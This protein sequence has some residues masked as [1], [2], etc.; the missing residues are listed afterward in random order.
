[1]PPIPIP[2]LPSDIHTVLVHGG[3]HGAWCW[4]RVETELRHL[5]VA[6]PHSTFRGV[7][8]TERRAL[9]S[10]LMTSSMPLLNTPR[11]VR[12]RRDACAASAQLLHP[13]GIIRGQFGARR[14]RISMGPLL[15]ALKRA[16]CASRLRAT[17]PSGI[18]TNLSPAVAG[19][20]DVDYPR[21]YIAM[22]EDLTYPLEVVRTFA[23]KAGV[24]PIVI[25]GDHCVM[26]SDAPRLAR[27]IAAT[28]PSR[29]TPIDS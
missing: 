17:N 18:R 6:V 12:P 8:T 23:L 3:S 11:G 15:P 21:R 2:M 25:T 4:W 1:M 7:A 22:D 10:Q 26:L 5:G 29:S 19:I 9:T 14:L 28:Q 20:E 27:A 13:G 16:P 24:D